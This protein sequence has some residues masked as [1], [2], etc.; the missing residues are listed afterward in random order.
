MLASEEGRRFKSSLAYHFVTK[1][2]ESQGSLTGLF[3]AR[4][5]QSMPLWLNGR[6]SVL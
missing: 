4:P 6:A 3:P 5:N 1:A 2:F